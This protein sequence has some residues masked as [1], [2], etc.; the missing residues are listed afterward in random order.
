M[1]IVTSL[2]EAYNLIRTMYEPSLRSRISLHTRTL[3]S[4]LDV[5]STAKSSFVPA[6][7]VKLIGNKINEK[8]SSQTMYVTHKELS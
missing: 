2:Y 8:L 4:S 5:I 6:D 3:T 7:L 1:A